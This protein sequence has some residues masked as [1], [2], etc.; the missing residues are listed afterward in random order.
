MHYG[1][2][3]SGI[4]RKLQPNFGLSTFLKSPLRQK[5]KTKIR[6]KNILILCHKAKFSL[7]SR[8]NLNT[9]GGVDGARRDNS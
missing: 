8:F 1:T 3:S 9:G 4:P 6:S 5:S 7:N 2:L